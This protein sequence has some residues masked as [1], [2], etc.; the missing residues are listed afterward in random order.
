MISA[1]CHQKSNWWNIFLN[2]RIF[3][4]M[5]FMGAFYDGFNLNL[6]VPKN[7]WILEI[8]I[9]I[10]ILREKQSI[11]KIS[12]LLFFTLG[13]RLIYDVQPVDQWA[14]LYV[15]I[16]LYSGFNSKTRFTSCNELITSYIWFKSFGSAMQVPFSLI[17]HR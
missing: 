17:N 9:L 15:N 14:N 11:P 10:Q 12:K 3:I 16:L 4:L 8:S 2:K 5:Q 13:K 1:Y 6:N 7:T